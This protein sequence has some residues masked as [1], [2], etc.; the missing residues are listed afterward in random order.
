MLLLADS[1]HLTLEHSTCTILLATIS[2]LL[3]PWDV[4][5]SPRN[6]S[7]SLSTRTDMQFVLQPS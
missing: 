7:I 4:L 3:M 2:G 5:Q 1:V 6:S